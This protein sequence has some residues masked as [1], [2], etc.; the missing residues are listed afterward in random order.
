MPNEMCTLDATGD[1]K[2][3]WSPDA[4]DEVDA[5]RAT[6]NTLKK[7]GY[8]A[9]RVRPGGDKGEAMGEF[10][11]RAEKVILIPPLVGG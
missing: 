7:K 5:A 2:L 4:P 11:P 9:Y 8:L 3:I 6:F 1:T 10:D